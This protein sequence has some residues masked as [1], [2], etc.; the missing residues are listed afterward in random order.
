MLEK[1]DIQ[2][3]IEHVFTGDEHSGFLE[4]DPNGMLAAR[5]YLRI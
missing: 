1:A 4:T 5:S 3:E 2:M